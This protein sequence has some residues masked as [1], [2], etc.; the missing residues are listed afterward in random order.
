MQVVRKHFIDVITDHK[1][2]LRGKFIF[3][4]HQ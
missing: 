3:P 1:Q 2:N 4:S